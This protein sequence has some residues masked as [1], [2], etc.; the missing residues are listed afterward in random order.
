[1][2]GTAKSVHE[3][4]DAAVAVAR[5][6]VE[7]LL[8]RS[9]RAPETV[10]G[11]PRSRWAV[12]AADAVR[13][14]TAAGRPDEPTLGH[15][16]ESRWRA[17]NETLAGE[18]AQPF[19]VLVRGLGLDDA[20]ARVVVFLAALEHD[21]DLERA[22]AFVWDDFTRKRPD[23]GFVIDVLGRGD[24]DARARVRAAL[25][26]DSPLRR[27]RVILVGTSSDLEAS[28]PAR[29]T[30][31]L[32]DRVVSHLFGDDTFDPV[33]DGVA[34]L[35]P[36]ATLSDLVLPEDDIALAR[37]ALGSG[38]APRVL[39]HGPAGTGK[40]MLVRA[41]AAEQAR[42]ILRVDVTELLRVMRRR[43]SRRRVARSASKRSTMKSRKTVQHAAWRPSSS[44]TG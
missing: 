30:V 36:A 15:D 6:W 24:P 41:L 11:V 35:Q 40:L 43:S 8:H 21:P 7:A 22:C 14:L 12:S 26:P 33:I 29:R 13:L 32:T 18:P 38:A 28:S 34:G 42:P 2:A 25:A 3:F 23:A 27:Y 19:A 4:L 20:A 39:L 17:L 9:A 37:R 31:R 10:E 16:A 5:G 1:V 44:R